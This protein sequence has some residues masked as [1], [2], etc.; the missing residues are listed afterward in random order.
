[1]PPRPPGRDA[2]HPPAAYQKRKGKL[3]LW[4]EITPN[5]QPHF[6]VAAIAHELGHVILHGEKRLDPKR[7]RQ[8]SDRRYP[9]FLARFGAK[10]RYWD[11][12]VDVFEEMTG[13]ADAVFQQTYGEQFSSAYELQ[14]EEL[15]RNRVKAAR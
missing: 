11:R 3:Q 8:L 7:L 9:G 10:R 12:Y 2:G 5:P 6:L 14:L 4:L 1:M 13:N 15:K